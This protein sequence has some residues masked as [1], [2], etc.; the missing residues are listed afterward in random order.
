MKT[1]ICPKCKQAI[2]VTEGT[3]YVICCDDVIYV[4]NNIKLDDPK[5]MKISFDSIKESLFKAFGVPKKYFTEEKN[6]THNNKIEGKNNNC[7]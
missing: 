2:T 5:I 6:E 1:I 4:D 7:R 3:E